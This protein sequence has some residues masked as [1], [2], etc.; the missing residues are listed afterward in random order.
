MSDLSP[1]SPI[2]PSAKPN[3]FGTPAVTPGV[4]LK[5]RTNIALA[6]ILARKDQETALVARA[7]EV[8]GTPL[9]E[10]GRCVSQGPLS[11]VWAGPGHWIAAMDGEDGQRFDKRLRDNFRGLASISDQTDGRT[12]ISVSGPKARNTLAKGV[13]LDLHPRAF[14]PGRAA[15][16]TAAHI[17]IYLW[18]TDDGPTFELAVFR[19][20]AGSF[21][22]FLMES[23][24]EYGVSVEG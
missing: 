13:P 9:P 14:G 12:V 15:A 11:L 22:H 2:A 5:E 20:F 3:R 7:R 16:T 21:W 17:G 24:A 10:T 23:A 1:R 18:Q 4:I 6:T 19:G 8:F